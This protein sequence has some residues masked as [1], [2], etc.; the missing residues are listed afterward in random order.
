MDR[1]RATLSLLRRLRILLFRPIITRLCFI[2]CC[3]RFFSF[4]PTFVSFLS[5][6]IA[7]RLYAVKRH[8]FIHLGTILQTPRSF[9]LV[10]NK[11]HSLFDRHLS[12]VS[13]SIIC[14]D[15]VPN[16]RLDFP[17]CTNSQKNN[18]IHPSARSRP[19]TTGLR[20]QHSLSMG[21]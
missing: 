2:S 4:L 3:S 6:L 12:R 8:S 19:T 20:R 16:I 7:G 17:C 18:E 13:I 11:N 21:Y 5:S 15:I 14:Y 9:A 10:Q 1:S